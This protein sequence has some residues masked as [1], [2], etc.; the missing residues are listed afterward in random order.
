M[1]DE[2]T[3]LEVTSEMLHVLGYDA[4]TATNGAAAI[5]VYRRARADG[6]PFDAVLL[7]LTIPGGMGGKDT[8]QALQSIDP[9][10]CAIVSSGYSSDTVLTYP[11]EHGFA[12]FI[13][14]P[15]DLDTLATTLADLLG[16]V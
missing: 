10:I 4:K 7:D 5:D 16:S 8:L 15:Y 1:D 12:A 9:E 14:K 6:R 11:R 3:I 13:R 2:P